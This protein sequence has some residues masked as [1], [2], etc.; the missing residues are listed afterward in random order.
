MIEMVLQND[1]TRDICDGISQIL[2]QPEFGNYSIKL[3]YLKYL[4]NN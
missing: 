2:R 4:A 1:F 3:L